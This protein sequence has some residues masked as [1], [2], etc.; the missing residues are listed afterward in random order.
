MVPPVAREPHGHQGVGPPDATRTEPAYD[1][2][3]RFA[4]LPP[5]AL[6]MSGGGSI[7]IGVSGW[8]YAPWRGHF[9][10]KGLPQKRELAFAAGRFPALEIN[11]TFYGLQRPE[12]F[13]RWAEATPAGFVFAIKGPRFITHI[14][15]LR[16]I[17]IPLANF[18]ASGLLR[19]GPKLGPLLWQFPPNFRFDPPLVEAFLALLPKDTEAAAELA[20]RHDGR[21]AGRAVTRTDARRPL[22]HAMEIRHDSFRDPAFVAL[23][24]RHGVALV[25]ADTVEW[26]RLMDQ[27]ADF[28]YCRLHGSTELYRSHY[29]PEA[30]DQW[31][32][33]VR[34]WA[35]GRAMHDGT[36]VAEP[37]IH[38]PPRD[39][40]VFFDNTDKLHA[41]EDAAQLMARLD[42]EWHPEAAKAA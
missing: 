42:I 41:P 34:A 23:L 3:A 6:V 36:F 16:D 37:E 18:L 4:N 38:P 39:V 25:C 7:R 9:Y 29:E 26:P 27:T 22:R 8:T 21:L 40:F 2:F 32:R 28:A 13:A 31:A 20:S 33:R 35:E 1:P 11:G 14:K 17:E 30:L 19:L 5:G 15:R 24:R 10:P 12:A